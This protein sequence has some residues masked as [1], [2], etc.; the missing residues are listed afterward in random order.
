M[1]KLV[2]LN[3]RKLINSVV[4]LVIFG[5]FLIIGETRVVNV[6]F[7]FC[8]YSLLQDSQIVRLSDSKI[9]R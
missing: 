9:V 8:H 6:Y 1:V 2:T 3:K 4:H 5:C 7:S